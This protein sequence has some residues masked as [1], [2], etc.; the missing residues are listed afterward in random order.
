MITIIFNV[1]IV[2]LLPLMLINK[3]RKLKAYLI[4]PDKK[5]M[6]ITMQQSSNIGHRFKEA[7]Q[8]SDAF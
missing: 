4:N 5:D 2:S 7:C 8:Y 1:I 3:N 6:P